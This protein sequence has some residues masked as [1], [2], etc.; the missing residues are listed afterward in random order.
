MSQLT[1]RLDDALAEQLKLHAAVLGRSVNSWIAAVLRAA[2]DPDLADSEAERTRA[3]LARAGLLATPERR[4]AG[5]APQPKRVR[6]ARR[7]AGAGTPLSHIVSE[8]R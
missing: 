5:T 2:V 4:E 6:A 1:V 7:A 8:R 3:R